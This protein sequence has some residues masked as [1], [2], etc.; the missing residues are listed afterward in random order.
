MSFNE[1]Y[2]AMLRCAS[3]SLVSPID[4][5][6][7]L[8]LITVLHE[9]VVYLKVNLGPLHEAISV[10]SAFELMPTCAPHVLVGR[11]LEDSILGLFVDDHRKA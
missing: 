11:T 5:S 9:S 2:A 10:G 8:A 6:Q 1:E 7:H 4:C 3:S